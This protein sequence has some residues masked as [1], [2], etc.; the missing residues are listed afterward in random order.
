MFAE[1]YRWWLGFCFQRE[2][3]K[4]PHYPG[5]LVRV[6]ERLP[7]PLSTW[8][9]QIEMTR[10]LWPTA[11]PALLHSQE[12]NI[13]L[14]SC[15]ADSCP[16]VWLVRARPYKTS[17]RWRSAS[18]MSVPAGSRWPESSFPFTPGERSAVQCSAVRPERI[19]LTNNVY[20]LQAECWQ[21]HP[22]TEEHL[23]CHRYKVSRDNEYF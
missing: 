1:V 18:R 10:S 15:L 19:Y 12:W 21:G 23:G 4:W 7:V 11:T 20:F 6:R 13:F 9:P 3:Q 5:C 14:T 2:R 22:G 17:S 8:R 16:V